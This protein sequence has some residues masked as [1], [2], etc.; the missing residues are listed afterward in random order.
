MAYRILGLTE[1]VLSEGVAAQPGVEEGDVGG[2]EAM[3]LLRNPDVLVLTLGEHAHD[4]RQQAYHRH[5][6]PQQLCV[7]STNVC[8]QHMFY[9]DKS[10][11]T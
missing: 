6:K 5:L 11:K 8:S 10:L 4:H 2:V 3:V 1:G 7:I 9:Y